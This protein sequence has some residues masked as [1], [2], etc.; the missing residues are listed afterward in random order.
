M[1]TKPLALLLAILIAIPSQAQLTPESQRIRAK[2]EVLD[3]N[4]KMTVKMRDGRELHG[5]LESS[6]PESFALNEV[7]QRMTLTIRYDEVASIAR[8]YGREGFLGRRVSPKKN[9]IAG[10]IIIGVLLMIVFVAV[11]NDK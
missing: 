2:I 3:P 10:V 6:A 11:A 7:D 4:S 1:N 9:L 5:S 8:N